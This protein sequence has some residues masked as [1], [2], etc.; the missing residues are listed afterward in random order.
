MLLR[1]A[2]SLTGMYEGYILLTASSLPFL[3]L[4]ALKIVVV[5]TILCVLVGLTTPIASLGLGLGTA[6]AL[7]LSRSPWPSLIQND[8]ILLNLILM[9]IV[10]A[11]VGPG[12]FSIDARLFGRR[13]INIPD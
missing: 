10:T 6:C 13:E 9:A 8:L 11:T 2:V 5:T 7:L 12:A 1:T 3:L 4:V